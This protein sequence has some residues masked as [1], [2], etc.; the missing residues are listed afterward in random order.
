MKKVI[1]INFQGRVIPI[2]ETAYEMLKR[3][4]ES[5]RQ[6]FA[7]EEGRDEII[8][9][10]EGRIGEL[11]SEQLKKGQP[12]ITDADVDTIMHSIGRPEDF[13]AQDADFQNGK[14]SGGEEEKTFASEA[15]SQ[16]HG[17]VRPERFYRDEN[18]KLIGGVCAGLAN[19]F[20][21]DKLVVRILF[22]IFT[23]GFGFGFIVYLILWV[24]IPSSAS[25]KIGSY[26]KRL[27]RDPDN[28]IIGGVCGG[29]ASYFG[30]SV[31]I[32]RLLFIV[33]FLS[34]V[35]NWNH[36]G[37]FNFPNFINLSFSPGAVLVYIILW[38][39]T[40]EAVTTSDKLEMKG[41]KVDL[42]SIKNTIQKDMEGFGERAKEFGKEVGDRAAKVGSEIGKR[43]K[44]ISSEAGPTIRKSGS[45]LGNIIGIIIKIFV[46]FILA[47][48]LI[49]I[50]GALFGIGIAVTGLLPFKPYI[51][52]AGWQSILV[53]GT[54]IFFI[55]VPVIGIITWII[56]KISKTKSNSNV[57][58]FGFSAM[59]ILGWICFIGLLASLRNDFSYHNTPA[60]NTVQIA[61]PAVNK[62]EVKYAKNYRYY[63]NSSFFHFEPFASLDEDTAFVRNIHL[64]ILKS[65]NDSFQVK[66]LKL[67]Y[68]ST[69]QL[70]QGRADKITFNIAQ[71]DS[72]LF[73]DR[74]I[75]IT[76]NEKFRNQSVYVTVYVP[77]GKKIIVTN[78]V[79]WGND[80]HIELGGDVDDWY[81]RNDDEGYNWDHDVEYIMTADGLQRTHPI[82]DDNDGEDNVVPP[83]PVETPATPVKPDSTKYHYEPSGE[84]A[85][86]PA[87]KVQASMREVRTIK[88]SVNIS[89]I[90]SAFF[91][92]LSL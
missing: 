62:L 23:M 19:Y 69:K 17:S 61:N 67:A 50:V 16:A 29:L 7:N 49:S 81:W 52:S 2:E 1:N 46:Y 24:A 39:I 73:F 20:G 86:S 21:I 63:F 90:T 42:N 38:L 74:G 33:P 51:I 76:K 27:F 70:A 89:D 59:W 56:R 41:E 64:R 10:I 60:E 9:D 3:Y 15:G 22:I 11:F 47:I 36:W 82:N 77:V 37:A 4:I 45:T 30:V 32:P 28:K 55:W 6:F 88:K 8:N 5:L 68:G 53:W 83:P 92:R 48:V 87:R 80:V 26:R 34:F 75:P 54:Y 66:M 91:E 43:G 14:T 31:W 72:T 71:Q 12:C 84:A 44:Q 18:N 65:G 79:G 78:G 58:R 40:P 35:T 13:E 57:M 85:D 25:E